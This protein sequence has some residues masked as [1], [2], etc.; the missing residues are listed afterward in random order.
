M[1]TE[2]LAAVSGETNA[3]VLAERLRVA[4]IIDSPE[5]KRNPAM[6]NKLALYSSLDADTARSILADAPA[7]NP[8]LAAM[9]KE[10]PTGINGPAPASFSTDPKAERL[11]EIKANTAAYN[12]AKGYTKV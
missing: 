10:G 9:D 2:A 8:Y 1:K 11:E 4:A 6:A 7:A 5:G 3:A 12:A